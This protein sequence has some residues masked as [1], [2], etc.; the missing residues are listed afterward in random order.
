MKHK[1]ALSLSLAVCILLSVF[2]IS[3]ISANAAAT[4]VGGWNFSDIAA[5]NVTADEQAILDKAMEKTEGISYTA[6]DV[7]ATQIVAGTNYA[8]LCIVSP[9]VPEPVSH[10]SI[11][12]VYRDLSGN[13]E[14]LNITDIAADNVEVTDSVNPHNSGSY[15]S[16]AKET[17]APVPENVK[18]ALDMN[19][20]LSLSSIAVL[21]TQVVSGTN[22][23]ILAY[24]TLVT[25]EPQTDLYVVDVYSSLDGKAEITSISPLCLSKYVGKPDVVEPETTETDTDLLIE[26]TTD[27]TAVDT[28]TDSKSTSTDKKSETDTANSS[29]VKSPKTGYSDSLFFGSALLGIAVLS[30]VASAFVVYKKRS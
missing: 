2:S 16:V 4:T 5:E 21:G 9:V 11:I 17:S 7:I 3:M 10:W 20:G 1:K 19:M 28:E 13:A 15:Y 22:Y 6:K 25:A 26:T 12:S 23:R 8:F 18:K 24:G 30:V 29:E 14:L 27:T